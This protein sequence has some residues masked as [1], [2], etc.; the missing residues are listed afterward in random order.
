MSALLVVPGFEHDLDQVFQ[1]RLQVALLDLSEVPPPV[2]IQF[3]RVD[4]F[5]LIRTLLLQQ[6]PQL[7]RKD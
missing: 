1:C 5:S 4:L 2:Q 7:Q 3:I 6:P